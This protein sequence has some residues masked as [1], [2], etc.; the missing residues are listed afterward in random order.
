MVFGLGQISDIRKTL[1]GPTL[2]FFSPLECDL[3][4]INIKLQIDFFHF[5]PIIIAPPPPQYY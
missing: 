4:M 1:T 2:V 3:D 5:K